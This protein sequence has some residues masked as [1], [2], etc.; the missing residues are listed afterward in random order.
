MLP[1]FIVIGGQKAG[2]TWVAEVLSHHPDVYMYPTEIPFFEDPDYQQRTLDDLARRFE[3]VTGKRAVGMKRPNLLTRSE[4]PARI[5]RDVPDA[6]LLAMLRDPIERAVSSYFHLM[7]SGFLPI[8]PVNVGMQRVISG[9]YDETWPAGRE[10]MIGYGFYHAGIMRYFEHVPRP[11]LLLM[12]YDRIRSDATGVFREMCRF[13]GI[14]ELDRPVAL[15]KRVMEGNYSIV[16]QRLA[17]PMR[18]LHRRVTRDKLRNYE[19]QGPIAAAARA[20]TYG[21]DRY[22]LAKLFPARRPVPSRAIQ[23]QLIEMYRDDV[24]ALSEFLG[25]DLSHWLRVREPS[26]S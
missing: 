9:D 5:A 1:N 8:E 11:Q 22:V 14:E 24:N 2:S 19:R 16:R 25:Q 18:H 15:E 23:E 3:G 12:L 7:R 21:I 26:A 20:V 4:C 17:R 10:R 13:L 6:K